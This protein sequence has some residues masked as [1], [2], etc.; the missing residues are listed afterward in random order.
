MVF[1]FSFSTEYFRLTTTTPCQFTHLGC[2]INRFSYGDISILMGP[3]EVKHG[4][5]VTNHDS[6]IFLLSFPM[7]LPFIA[8]VTSFSGVRAG[9]ATYNE[10]VM[11]PSAVSPVAGPLAVRPSFTVR[12]GL[13][14]ETL[15]PLLRLLL[16]LVL[17]LRDFCK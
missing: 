2:S 7:P 14:V 1:L 11:P 15:R 17:L 12:D 4:G 5:G 8:F 10:R 13:N 9:D 3:M 16:V 6:S